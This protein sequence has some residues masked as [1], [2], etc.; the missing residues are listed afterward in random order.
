MCEICGNPHFDFRYVSGE[1]P[2][3]ILNDIER[4]PLRPGIQVNIRHHG[5]YKGLSEDWEIRSRTFILDFL[6]SGNFSCKILGEKSTIEKASGISGIC[7][8]P[9]RTLRMKYPSDQNVR[10]IMMLIDRSVMRELVLDGASRVSVLLERL[11][12]TDREYPPLYLD[13]RTSP[14]ML[15]ALNQ[16][17]ACPYQGALGQLFM[18]SKMLELLSMRLAAYFIDA[19]PGVPAISRSDRDKIHHARRILETS[20]DNT[21]TMTNLA[22]QIGMSETKLKQGFKTI[23]GK[24]VFGFYKELRLETA[25]K[26]LL[27]REWNVTEAAVGVGYSSLSHFSQAFRKQFGFSPSHLRKNTN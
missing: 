27:S 5:V 8:A 15:V 9:D 13:S 20:L 1:I 11:L 25:K 10:W 7:Y 2:E 16:M 22:R 3:Y 4:H 12:E 6:V 18:E 23:F 24:P 26:M 21:P 14:E 19:S 17:L